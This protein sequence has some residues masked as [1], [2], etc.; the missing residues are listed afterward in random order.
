MSSPKPVRKGRVLPWDALGLAAERVKPGLPGRVP[1]PYLEAI[2]ADLKSFVPRD[3]L[4]VH[5]L[6]RLLRLPDYLEALRIRL[7]RGRLSPDKDLAKS[8]RLVPFVRS[9]GRL[10]GEAAA[11]PPSNPKARREA[12]MALEDLR[13]LIEEF[14]ISLFAPEVKTAHPVSSVR[15]AVRIKEIE[16]LLRGG[17]AAKGKP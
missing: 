3:F 6:D 7:D 14:K 1:T 17:G 8:D 13:W 9:F 2:R 11:A 12:A 15:L 16:T 4:T 5:P 10:K